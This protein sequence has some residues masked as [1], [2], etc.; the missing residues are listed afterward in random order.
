MLARIVIS[1]DIACQWSK[2]FWNRMLEYPNE[3]KVPSETSVE[4]GIPNWH[5]NGHGAFCRDNL[6][7][8]YIPG[9]GRTCGEDVETSWAHTNP[10]AS[11]TREMGPGARRETL[12]DHW[13]GWNFGKI[14]GFRTCFVFFNP[15]A[16]LIFL[17]PI[18]GTLFLKRF[19]DA[20][21]M[22]KK[23]RDS[24]R[25]FANTFPSETIQKWTIMVE[26]WKKDCTK[27]SPYAEPD[28]SKCCLSSYMCC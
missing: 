27:P 24:Y 13:G 14:I 5:V 16:N 22:M 18:T 20:S 23:H 7:L 1:Y 8:N 3:M 19:K 6:S 28:N 17:I 21:V 15:I 4:V 25:Q 10:L 26:D 11:S 2:G 12:N 9:V